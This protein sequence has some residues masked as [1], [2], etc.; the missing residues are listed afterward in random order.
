MGS[1]LSTF[2]TPDT[3]VTFYKCLKSDSIEDLSMIEME[4]PPL[5]STIYDPA[6]IINISDT[7]SD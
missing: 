4:F 7:D 1:V 5:L 3:Q 2:Y 6:L